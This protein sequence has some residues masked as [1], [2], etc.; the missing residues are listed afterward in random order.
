M[1]HMKLKPR[2]SE[3]QI[4]DCEFL[5]TALPFHQQTLPYLLFPLRILQKAKGSEKTNTAAHSKLI[6]ILYKLNPLS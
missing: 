3:S 5:H 4:P 1:V 2:S 6:E